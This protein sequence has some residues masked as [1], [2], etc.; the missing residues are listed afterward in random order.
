M[1]KR[2]AQVNQPNQS[3][4]LEVLN[5]IV[6]P[7]DLPT[8]HGIITKADN[9]Y[10]NKESGASALIQYAIDNIDKYQVDDLR[11][12]FPKLN[13][14]LTALYPNKI[15][16]NIYFSKIRKPISNKYGLN[17]EEYKVSQDL[18]KIT[19]A[20]KKAI[21]EDY[22]IKVK[23][24]NRDRQ[25]F[26]TEDVL[27]V[28]Y[29]M[30]AANHWADQA[31]GLLICCGARPIELLVKNKYAP[32]GDAEMWVHIENLAKKRGDKQDDTVN[33]PLIHLNCA[34]FI[35]RV[36]KVRN[37]ED[38]KS[39]KALDKHGHL[40]QNV[41]K[42]LNYHL[43]KYEIFA[44]DNASIL[45]KVYANLAYSLYADPIKTN[46]NVFLSDTLGHDRSDI[47][48]ASSYSTVVVVPR[49][50]ERDNAQIINAIDELRGTA[51]AIREDVDELKDE[52][53]EPEIIRPPVQM[54]RTDE[55]IKEL[56]RQTLTQMQANNVNIT[57]VNLR[58]YSRLGS[59]Q[60]N[61]YY[62]DL[63]KE[64]EL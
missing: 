62:K 56:L 9:K 12:I 59:K 10:K 26:Y 19:K 32:V 18:I 16:R 43:E 17:S 25:V 11:A 4:M 30:L 20:E 14:I 3:N 1:P 57:N 35:E 60:V 61:K 34:E 23:E 5:Q 38:F 27:E 63:K 41:D 64:L 48:T 50:K 44:N 29:K 46:L 28:M 21:T 45:R 54:N 40:S 37:D 53:K 15:T 13:T 22:N 31:L 33:R 58:K 47:A 51:R 7:Y 39:K 52:M 8:I 2:A 55:E 6:E 42:I 49:A 36:N 24:K